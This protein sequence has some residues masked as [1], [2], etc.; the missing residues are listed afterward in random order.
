[1]YVII[2]CLP[3]AVHMY[4]KI[5]TFV[6]SVLMYPECLEDGL[7]YFRHSEKLCQMDKLRG[8]RKQ[9]YT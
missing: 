2:I 3:L 1:M 6:C 7:V 9:L 5:K 4:C 8:D